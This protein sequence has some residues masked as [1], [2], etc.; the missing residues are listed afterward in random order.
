METVRSNDGTLIA[1]EKSGRGAPLVLVHGTSA[2]HTRW[3]PVLQPFQKRF[4]VYAVDRRGRG[5]SGDTEPYAIEHEFEDIVAI[6]NSIGEPV[7]LLGHSYGGI[8]ALEAAARTKN[9][10]R[11]ILY[12]PP[13][14][15]GADIYSATVVNTMRDL[16]AEGDRDG[17]IATFMREVPRVPPPQLE[18]LRSLPAWQGRVAAA[19]T[20]LRELEVSNNG[21]QFEPLK[22]ARV[23]TPTL[24][25]L[26][27]ASPDFFAAAINQVHRALPNSQIV[28]MPGQQHVA[29]DSAPD[30]FVKAVLDFLAGQN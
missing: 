24:L 14:S 21:Y 6:I 23:T 30:L 3:A 12:E 9:L 17:V 16:L 15:T 10:R 20:I 4:T 18:L 27:G 29:M 2:D 22:F 25:L 19:H 26:G 5:R 8:C 28:V 7:N 13:I 1:Y 11:L